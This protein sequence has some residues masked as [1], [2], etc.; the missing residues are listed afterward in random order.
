MEKGSYPFPL[1][2][3]PEFYRTES[4]WI[5]YNGKCGLWSK[6]IGYLWDKLSVGKIV[7]KANSFTG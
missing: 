3:R 2:T 6:N 4:L 5:I 7:S 1:L